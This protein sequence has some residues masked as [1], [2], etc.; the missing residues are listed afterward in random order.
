MSRFTRRLPDASFL[1][2]DLTEIPDWCLHDADITPFDLD[3]VLATA[4]KSTVT[5]ARTL[6]REGRIKKIHRALW[7]VRTPR[8]PNT[9]THVFLRHG[10]YECYHCTHKTTLDPCGHI[11]AVMLHEEPR[12]KPRREGKQVNPVAKHMARLNRFS[13]G[14][15]LLAGLCKCIQEPPRGR[16]RPPIGFQAAAFVIVFREM[17]GKPLRDAQ[18][19]LANFRRFLPQAPD[20]NAASRYSQ[21]SRMLLIL[22]ELNLVA[23]A[24]LRHLESHWA[25]D[26]TGYNLEEY[27]SFNEEKHRLRFGHLREAVEASQ[28]PGFQ[29]RK[30]RRKSTR[31][32][33]RKYAYVTT[34]AGTQ[35]G[36]IAAAA[37]DSEP[38]ERE[39]GI[40]VYLQARR[41]VIIDRLTGDELHCTRAFYSI[42]DRDAV[43]VLSPPAKHI[44]KRPKKFGAFA[45]GVELFLN[46]DPETL[47]AYGIHENVEAT[48]ASLKRRNR[49]FLS[50]R[51]GVARRVQLQA[52]ILA[53]NI[54]CLLE[55]YYS[56]GDIPDFKAATNHVQATRKVYVNARKAPATDLE[57]LR[58]KP[59]HAERM[60][61]SKDL[62]Q[63]LEAFP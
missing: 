47:L 35:T 54:D 10:L 45:D 6:I 53:H 41:G 8:K 60:T 40:A 25:I 49:P 7:D 36:V 9:P 29:N 24:S 42:E 4:K 11:L 1:R 56:Y 62:P 3:D 31:G 19:L 30:Q 18:S 26:G 38:R 43:Q 48:N 27:G 63:V 44:K 33:V 55:A 50:N 51:N 57:G 32:R 58:F 28:A 15:K 61:L 12:V 2:P 20:V 23:A 59:G 14:L 39:A 37:M 13:V 34:I 22:E 16:G 17:V 21:K 52:I 46:E 5:N